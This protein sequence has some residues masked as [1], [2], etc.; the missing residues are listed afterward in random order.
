MK[1]TS[2]SPVVIN[3]MFRSGTSLIW[4]VLK[5]DTKFTEAFYEPL[6]QNS[7]YERPPEVRKPYIRNLDIVERW[8][9]RY[10]TEK[11]LLGRA[12]SF[13]ELKEYLDL[14][15]KDNTIVKFTRLNL[16]LKWF[17]EHFPNAFII[18]IIR[19]PRDVCLSYIMR[20]DLDFTYKSN[21]KQ[22]YR[23]NIK[24]KF[25]TY[26]YREYFNYLK[27]IPKWKNYIQS[28]KKEPEYVKILGLWKI[29][30]TESLE[31]LHNYERAITFK[32]EDFIKKPKEILHYIYNTL[33]V[34]I[35]PKV[36]EE[37]YKPNEETNVK[38]SGHKFHLKISTDWI[39]RWKK[40]DNNIWERGIIK[41][42]LEE[43]MER[44]DYKI[45]A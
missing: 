41:A 29:N 21:I 36:E 2:I 30:V 35:D 28:L 40:T 12:D 9:R 44:L 17:T 34:D 37:L 5:G 25:S 7:P 1:S 10:S 14:I 24:K 22:A 39:D 27:N 42:D 26:F 19:D 32:H 43:L 38:I 3:G 11:L 23:Q 8:S 31:A 6:H 16:R 45:E 15:L 18:N 33:N 4:R 13:P 20:A